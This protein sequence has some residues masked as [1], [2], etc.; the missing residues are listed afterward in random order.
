MQRGRGPSPTSIVIQWYR[1]TKYCR[2]ERGKVTERRGY[3]CI[4][5]DAEFGYTA[6]EIE[7]G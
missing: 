4:S 1:E 2:R 7:D 6:M 5:G 3:F